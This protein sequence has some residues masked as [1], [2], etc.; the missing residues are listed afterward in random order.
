MMYKN[1]LADADWKLLKILTGDGTVQVI[2]DTTGGS[3]R[4]YKVLIE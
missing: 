4:F 1:S 3:Q 2:N